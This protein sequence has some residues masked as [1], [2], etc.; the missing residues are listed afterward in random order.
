[1]NNLKMILR[2][3]VVVPLVLAGVAAAS[4]Q[5]PRMCG[6]VPCPA[7]PAKPQ[8][9]QPQRP[10]VAA[11]AAQPQR[12]AVAA[13]AV[14]Q[15]PAVAGQP[16][17]AQQQ[18]LLQQRQQAAQQAAQQRQMQQQQIMQQRQQ[19]AQQAAQAK[20]QAQAQAQQAAQM[21]AQQAQQL[22]LQQQQAQQQKLQQQ[23]LLRQQQMQGGRPAVGQPGQG[24]AIPGQ[25]MQGARPAVGQPGQGQ[26][27][28]GQPMQGARP[29]V[30]QPGQGQ[31]IPGQPMQGQQ[32][33]G[34]PQLQAPGMVG[35][36]P[37]QGQMRPQIGTPGVGPGQMQP[38]PAVGVGQMPGQQQQFR[39]E[40]RGIGA[41]GAA[42]I[43]FGAGVVGGYLLSNQMRGVTEVHQHRETFVD[44]G[45]RYVREPGRVIIRE[46][47]GPA[48]IRHDESERFAILGY[49][50]QVVQEGG[51]VRSF[52]DRPDGVRVITV[53][54]PDGRLIRRI[55]R[56]PDGRE[57]IL[58]DNDFRPRPAR[59]VDQVVVLPPPPLTIPRE[60]YIVDASVAD[61]G[62]IYEALTAPPLTR[63]SRRYTLDEVRYSPDLRAQMRSVDVNTITFDSGSWVV[64][65]SQVQRLSA[66]AGAIGKAVQA[67]Q[68]EVFLI[69][70]HTDAVGDQDDNLSLSDRRAAAVAEILTRDF[71]IPAENLTTQ[72]YGETQLRVQTGGDARVNRRVTVRRI[73]P[74][75]AEQS[76]SQS[77]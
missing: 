29:A 5:Q 63:V 7:A 9:A 19:A 27:I 56:Y 65:P 59:F 71:G 31:A 10:A 35:G 40:S 53:T 57:V 15:R 16:A 74:L 20:A 76:Q 39:R 14:Q 49:K 26:A 38:P 34:R 11:P 23:Q 32:L 2:M 45:V 54:D 66:I 70:G 17:A 58:I 12:P 22:K 18:Q 8:A 52:Y 1:M 24:Q 46:E 25:P 28:P 68:S 72:G 13:P 30:V 4:A 21:K 51:Y 67:D 3:G 69:E 47:G 62:T 36:Q 77:Q 43:G 75:I 73:T 33:Q 60:R 64:E 37:G 48:Y 55:R 44:G 42:A 41:A 6:A 50:P 61:E